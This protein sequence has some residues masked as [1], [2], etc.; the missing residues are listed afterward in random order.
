MVPLTDLPVVVQRTMEE[1]RRLQWADLRFGETPVAALMVVMMLAAA[2]LVLLARSLHAR[3]PGR[4]HVTLPAILPLVRR[5]SLSVTRH[6]AFV[7]F[8]LGVPLFAVALADPYTAFTYEKVTYPGRRIAVAID[9]SSSMMAPFTSVR[10]KNKGG[11]TFFTAVAAAEYFL[12]LRMKGPYR[13]LMALIEFGNEAYVVTPFTTDYE[14]LLLSVKLIGNWAEWQRFP[15]PGTV[16][17]QAINQTVQLF[18]AFDFLNASGNLMVIFSDGQDSHATLEGRSLDEI[19]AEAR[20]HEIPV[21]LIRTAFNRA[22]GGVLPDELWKGAIERTGGRFYPAADEDT[23][24]RAVNE[25]DRLS[26]GRI[27]MREYT[28]RQPRFAGYA[29]VAVGLW[30]VAGALKLGVSYFRTFP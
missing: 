5:T 24:I 17:I 18:R 14:N 16:I 11:P 30:L 21:Y 7:L 25:I 9:A 26:A 23:I 27:E 15:D 2:L 6:A 28:A 20:K 8:L 13:D 29:L 12:R 1:W 19:L 10:F 3:R 22:L 4:T